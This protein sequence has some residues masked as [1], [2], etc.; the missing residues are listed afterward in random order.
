MEV[1]FGGAAD[2]SRSD[3]WGEGRAGGAYRRAP[4]LFMIIAQAKMMI[5][6]VIM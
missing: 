1:E 2:G 3:R 5:T 4:M 6:S